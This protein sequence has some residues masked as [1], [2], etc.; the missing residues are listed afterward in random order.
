M[1][2]YYKFFHCMYNEYVPCGTYEAAR[3]YEIDTNTTMEEKLGKPVR[4]YRENDKF[5]EF[6]KVKKK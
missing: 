6:K 1:K 4:Y 3:K 2:L 5:I